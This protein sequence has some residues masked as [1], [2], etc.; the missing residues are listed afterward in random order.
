[1]KEC[2]PHTD[3]KLY[4]Y[5][6]KTGKKEVVFDGVLNDFY[7]IERVEYIDFE[8]HIALLYSQ[9]RVKTDE[10]YEGEPVYEWIN[11]TLKCHLDANGN[12][13]DIEEIK[14]E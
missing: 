8:E 3:G 7:E 11:M 14:L 1:M 6:P 10:M 5:D 4:R 2:I 13:V 9:T 12:F